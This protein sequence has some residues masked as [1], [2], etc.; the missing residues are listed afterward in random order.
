M[1]ANRPLN[2]ESLREVAK[3]SGTG[4]KATLEHLN[5]IGLIDDNEAEGLEE[6]LMDTTAKRG[7]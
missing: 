6:D 1:E 5:N 3:T 4:K 7:S 2:A